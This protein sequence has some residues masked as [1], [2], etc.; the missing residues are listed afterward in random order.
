MAATTIALTLIL[1][2]LVRLIYNDI[3]LFEFVE[4][5]L[6]EGHIYIYIYSNNNNNTPPNNKHSNN[7][8]A[9]LLEAVLAARRRRQVREEDL[10]Q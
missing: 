10:N 2:R 6:Q 4:C 7:N 9:D 5:N 8:R 3:S 1:M